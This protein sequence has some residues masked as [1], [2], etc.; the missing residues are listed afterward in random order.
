M[1]YNELVAPLQR[2]EPSASCQRGIA[3]AKANS[4]GVDVIYRVLRTAR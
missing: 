1:K 3:A 2:R 4:L